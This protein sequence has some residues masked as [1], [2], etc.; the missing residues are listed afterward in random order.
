MAASSLHYTE[1]FGI[2]EINDHN[3]RL[4]WRHRKEKRVVLTPSTAAIMTDML[5]AVVKEGTG[6]RARVLGRPVAGKT[7][8]TNEFRDA[9]FIGFS[10]HLTAGVW[11]GNDNFTPLGTSETGSKAALPIW[12]DFMDNAMKKQPLEYFH[13]PDNI[14]KIAIDVKSGETVRQHSPNTA[15][16]MFRKS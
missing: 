3:G 6:K 16:A 13:I 5:Q 11:V 14:I 9:L 2:V 1:P 8:T 10:P 7:G 15:V 4:I 12:I